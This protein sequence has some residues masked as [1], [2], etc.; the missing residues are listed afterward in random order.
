MVPMTII[1]KIFSSMASI[2]GLLLCSLP[3]AVVGSNFNHYFN[4]FNK[5]KVRKNLE[6]NKRNKPNVF[7]EKY[8]DYKD[9]AKF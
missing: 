8:Y 7:I 5:E 3:I 6:R 2:W 9:L 1:G 4:L